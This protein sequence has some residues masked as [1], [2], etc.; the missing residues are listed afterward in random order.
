VLLDAFLIGAATELLRNGA[1]APCCTAR[2]RTSRRRQQRS[3]HAADR[4]RAGRLWCTCG[5][6]R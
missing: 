5:S 2:R 4:R 1:R 6:R 3:C